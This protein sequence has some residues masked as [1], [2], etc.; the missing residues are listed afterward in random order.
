[1]NTGLVS[2]TEV[3]KFGYPRYKIDGKWIGGDQ[4]GSPKASTGDTISFETYKNDRGY[5]TLK[6]ASV[7]KV[8]A[9]VAPASSAPA[10]SGLSGWDAKDV[11]I[12]RTGARNSAAALLTVAAQIGA[13]GHIQKA[14]ANTQFDIL[15]KLLD[16]LT[17]KFAADSYH[18]PIPAKPTKAPAVAGAEKELESDLPE[19]APADGT[20]S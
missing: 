14:K 6:S 19:A 20:W 10:S 15:A 9:Q 1:V 7:A 3:N 13:L 11:R 17:D 2:E 8:A 12:N 4:K 18:A 5:L 16:E